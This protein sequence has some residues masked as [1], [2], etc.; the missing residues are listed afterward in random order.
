MLRPNP[1]RI[2]AN[3]KKEALA[4][5][6]EKSGSKKY[7]VID[8]SWSEASAA[9]KAAVEELQSAV[10][11]IETDPVSRFV[12]ANYTALF[13]GKKPEKA[14]F[15]KYVKA[16]E[17]LEQFKPAGRFKAMYF[18]YPMGM[19]LDGEDLDREICLTADYIAV[20]D[21]NDCMLDRL[22]SIA[23]QYTKETCGRCVF[24]HE[25]TAQI[26]MILSE[27]SQEAGSL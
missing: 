13:N 6:E 9:L 20:Y 2:G 1:Y 11:V 7:I 24:G 23:E 17:I 18:G 12:Y 19:L 5:L 15:P 26:Q 14:I 16:K 3:T 25:G 10:E 22:L 8:R 4:A 27:M 21:E